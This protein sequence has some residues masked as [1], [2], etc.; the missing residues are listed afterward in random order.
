MKCMP[1]LYVAPQIEK[2]NLLNSLLAKGEIP[3]RSDNADCSWC[4]YKKV[5]ERLDNGEDWRI[6]K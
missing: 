4:G 5:C 2:L 1:D 3:K 6:M